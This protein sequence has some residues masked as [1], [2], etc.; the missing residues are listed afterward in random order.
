M[1]YTLILINWSSTS[2]LPAV[3]LPESKSLQL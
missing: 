1:Q 2:G 3:D